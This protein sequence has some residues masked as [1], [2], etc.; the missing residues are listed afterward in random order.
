[1]DGMRRIRIGILLVAAGLLVQTGSASLWSP[2]T[3]ILSAVVGVP[4]VG[5]GSVAI[6]LGIRKVGGGE[7][8]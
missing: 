2:G 5:I 8:K 7:G 6:W 3:F 4:L 1:M